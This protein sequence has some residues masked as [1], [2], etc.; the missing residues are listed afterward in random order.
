MKMTFFG[1]SIGLA[2]IGSTGIAGGIDHLSRYKFAHAGECTPQEINIGFVDSGYWSG[3]AGKFHPTC[4]GPNLQPELFNN[5]GE[6]S[7]DIILNMNGQRQAVRCC[8]GHHT[9][10]ECPCGEL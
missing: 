4:L 6:P 5:I 1:L 9:P 2:A 3:K 8:G 10:R 7:F